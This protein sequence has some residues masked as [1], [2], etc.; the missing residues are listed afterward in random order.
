MKDENTIYEVLDLARK[1]ERITILKM[2]TSDACYIHAQRLVQDRRGIIP[3]TKQTNEQ[4][5]RIL[6]REKSQ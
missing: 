3:T 1:K 5:C 4:K 6:F 2:Y